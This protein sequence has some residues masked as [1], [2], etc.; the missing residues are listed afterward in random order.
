LL[1]LC[2]LLLMGDG[3]HGGRGDGGSSGPCHIRTRAPVGGA[4]AIPLHS[5]AQRRAPMPTWKFKLD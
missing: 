5:K 3:R 1:V 2:V 4:W